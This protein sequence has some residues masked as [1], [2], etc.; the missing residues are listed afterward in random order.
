MKLQ[1]CRLAGISLL[2]LLA[3][4]MNAAAASPTDVAYCKKL[5]DL[6]LQYV[7]SPFDR[8]PRVPP[9]NVSH[10]METCDSETEAS[11]AVLERA[12]SNNGFTLPKR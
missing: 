9:A 1:T 11:T 5:S 7:G 12:L 8:P 6:Y 3:L 2:V 10:A 4:A